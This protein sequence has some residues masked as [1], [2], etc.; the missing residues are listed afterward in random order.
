MKT[1]VLG[2]EQRA[3]ALARMAERELDILVVGAGVVGAGT[4][5]DATTRGLS[6]GLVEARDWASGTSSRSSKLIHGGLRYLEMLDFGLVREALRE[7]G[8]LLDRIAPHLVRPVPFLYPLQHRGWERFYAGSGVALYDAM[9]LSSGH[10]RGLPRHRHLTRTGALR[11]APCLRKD[12][13]VGALQYYDAQVDDA[14]FVAALVRTAASY[15][16]RV[17]NRARVT[18]FLRE[19]ERVV[20]VRVLDLESGDGESAGDFR[21]YEI[22]A[23]QVVNATGVWTDDTQ[24]MIAERGQFHVRASKGIHLVVPKD[25]IHSSTG[26]ILRTETS[27]LF[28]IPWG[29]HWIV[30]TTDTA[31][32][33]DKAHPAASSAD[34]DYLLEHVN[35]VLAVPLTRDDV[36]GVYAGLRPLLAGESDATSKLSREHTVAHPV[37]GL[38]VVAG[39]KYTTYRVMA[40][41]AVDAAVHGLDQRVAD[42]CTEEIRLAGA[43]GFAALWNGRARIASR[44]GL[45]EVRVEHLLRRYGALTQEVL[46]LVVADPR[47]GEPLPAADD[48]LKAEIVYACSHEGAR[49]LEDV[50]TRRTRISIETFDRGTRSARECAELMGGVLGWSDEQ[51]EREVQH[52]LKRVEAERESQL[53]PDDQTADAARLG[54]PDTVPL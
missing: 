22:R 1:A 8:L 42:C 17:A 7:R 48:Y 52:Y 15:G 16:A 47:L 35:S 34:I 50:L 32:D 38:V 31:W 24:A 14:R 40:K 29:R 41:D 5:L 27:V 53:Q 4:A 51:V 45:H 54:A 12:A 39:G 20:G 19:G 30:G 44:A 18:E 49:H 33:L 25:R 11:I 43:E 10:G 21:S 6:T 13:L 2:P 26:L 36:E 46:D 3:E 9:S 37:P 23:K 28:V